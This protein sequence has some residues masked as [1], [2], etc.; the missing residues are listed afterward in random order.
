MLNA[1]R[2]GGVTKV[3]LGGVVVLI[4]AAFALDYRTSA[5]ASGDECVAEMDDECIP[6]QDYQTLLRLVAPPGA[7]NKELREAGFVQYAVDALV[8][9]ALLLHEA[10]RLGVGVSEDELDR[11]LSLGRIHFS[12]PAD[13]PIPN[14]LA[15]GRPFPKTGASATVT[16]VRVTN[17]ETGAFDYDIYRRQIQSRLRMSPKAFK[18]SQQAEVVAARVREMVTNPVRVSESE[19]WQ[20]YAREKSEATARIVDAKYEWFQRFAARVTDARVAEFQT[21]STALVDEAWAEEQKRWRDDCVLVSELVF[22]YEP[23]ADDEGK[24]ATLARAEKAVALLKQG[25]D[26]AVLAKTLSDSSSAAGGGALGCLEAD[27]GPGGADLVAAVSKVPAG[28]TSEILE[29]PAGKH[30][31]LVHGKQ[32]KERAAELGRGFLVRRLA[33]EKLAQERAKAFAEKLLEAGK[34]GGDLEALTNEQARAALDIGVEGDA[35]TELT[36]VAL[37]DESRPLMEVSRTFTAS[38][39]PIFAVKGDFDVAGA[40]FELA[41]PDDYLPTPVETHTGYA[42][43]Q[44]KDKTVASREQFD[45]EKNEILASARELRRAEVLTS[46]VARLRARVKKLE[47]NAKHTG[48]EQDGDDPASPAGP[49]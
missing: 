29:S 45:Q 4:I 7:T 30:V 43:V 15:A 36:Q 41:K 23:G 12:W 19:V 35:L 20:Q 1:F 17:T 8:E 21:A 6:L 44:L 22:E 14:A 28:Q 46:Y 27:Y 2:Q 16:H 34:A 11:L 47:L 37:E 24:Q 5:P 3:L 48:A 13:A 18:A 32:T 10:E 33:L 42:V 38:G 49:G 9:R 25:V 31:F 39:S 26:F 40:V